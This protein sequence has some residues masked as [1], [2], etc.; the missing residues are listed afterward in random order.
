M[1][2]RDR[3]LIEKKVGDI[4]PQITQQVG[5]LHVLGRG[6]NGYT[7]E[8]LILIFPPG[9]Q[10][11]SE[12]DKQ[13]NGNQQKNSAGNFMRPLIADNLRN[14]QFGILFCFQGSWCGGLVFL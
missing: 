13:E 11:R 9:K 10:I 12:G 8:N 7:P 6:Q 14:G 2:I 4:G 1:C 3:S 5:H